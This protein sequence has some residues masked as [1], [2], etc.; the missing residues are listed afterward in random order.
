M[1]V[2][3][4]VLAGRPQRPHPARQGALGA[5]EDLQEGHDAS[6]VARR[7]RADRRRAG[8][9]F[10]RCADARPRTRDRHGAVRRLSVPRHLRAHD[11]RAR[12]HRPRAG[13]H[14]HVPV[15]AHPGRHDRPPYAAGQLPSRSAASRAARTRRAQTSGTAAATA[16]TARPASSSVRPASTSATARSSSASSARCASMPATRSWT[17]S[18]GRADLIAYDTVAKQEAKAPGPRTSR[19]KLVRP[20]TMLYAGMLASGRRRSCWSAG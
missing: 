18:A 5:V 16:S 11:L 6:V 10:P 12:R 8:L 1:I 4:A 17:R 20:R 14:L 3:R 19:C 13:L 15:A 2:G 7:R 9:L